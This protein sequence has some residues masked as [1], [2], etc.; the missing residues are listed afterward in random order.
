MTQLYNTAMVKGNPLCVSY[1]RMNAR[2]RRHRSQCK[3][4]IAINRRPMSVV[5]SERVFL[6]W[7][8]WVVI[9]SVKQ[10]LGYASNHPMPVQQ[11]RY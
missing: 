1:G 7:L 9:A 4:Y 3:K 5:Q 11:M 8:H 6:F 2:L 10:D